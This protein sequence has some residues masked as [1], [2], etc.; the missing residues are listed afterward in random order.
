M[1]SRFLFHFVLPG[2]ACDVSAHLA[3]VWIHRDWDRDQNPG[4]GPGSG[5]PERHRERHTPRQYR[6]QA[7]GGLSQAP[8]PAPCYG[9]SVQAMQGTRR[10]AAA[11]PAAEPR[12]VKSPALPPVS[13]DSLSL[14][15]DGGSAPESRRGERKDGGPPARSHRRGAEEEEE[16]AG[17][18]SAG[19]NSESAGFLPGE[20]EAEAAATDASGCEWGGLAACAPWQAVKAV[21]CCVV[22]CGV[23]GAEAGAGA[24][25]P[26]AGA[27]ESP[28]TGA[29][30]AESNT[31]R[32][33][34]NPAL[35]VALNS[36]PGPPRKAGLAGN[37]FNYY[38][39]KLRGQRVVWKNHPGRGLPADPCRRDAR[40][41]SPR[42]ESPGSAS[43]ASRERL[44]E[45]FPSFLEEDLGNSELNVSMSSAELDEYI[46]RKLL[47]LFSIHQIDM[48]AQCTSDTT[49]ISKSSEI[50]ELID[51][52]TKDYKINEKD[53][54]CRIVT[55]IVRIS[56]RKPK[57]NKKRWQEEPGE[58]RLVTLTSAD[59]RPQAET[60]L[61]SEEL[62]LEISVV[63]PLDLKARQMHGLPSPDLRKDDSLQDTET[64][65][66]G[67]P[68]LK[69]YL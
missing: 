67:A 60:I 62:N 9:P 3:Q 45:E 63:D 44:S 49:F 32:Y 40:P 15:V 25:T 7:A 36:E 47:E 19:S 10:K 2:A 59:P 46:N 26:C 66:S 14:E 24:Y 57:R 11:R 56:T 69:V 35:G 30:E 54:E 33:V 5:P 16:E 41:G 51:S 27:A 21:L 4:S 23:C 1:D 52:I 43:P 61:P 55:G 38:D 29:K 68:L 65:S 48:L 17:D 8:A 13:V 42:S 12:L 18:S 31:L 39:V 37:S 34:E 58:E 64:D 50:S 22:T 28:T 20:A 53:A 6:A